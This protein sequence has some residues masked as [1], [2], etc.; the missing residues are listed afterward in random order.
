MA[1][2]Q[3]DMHVF[4]R[5]LQLWITYSPSEPLLRRAEPIIRGFIAALWI[6]EK[7]DTV[8]CARL[9]QRLDALGVPTDMQWGIYALYEFV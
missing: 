9:M 3:L 7:P 5:G 8:P 1:V 4:E 6:S 2:V